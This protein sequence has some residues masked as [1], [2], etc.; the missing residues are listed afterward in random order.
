MDNPITKFQGWWKSALNQSPLKH[1]SA[2]CVSTIDR[3]GFPSGRFVDLKSVDEEGFMFCTDLDSQKGQQILTNSKVALT[4]WWD[5][6]GYQVRI[7]G[8]AE[9]VPEDEAEKHW[10]ARGRSAQLTTS[11]CKQSQVLESDDSLQKQLAEEE[12]R[13]QGVDVPKPANWGGF[14][15]RPESIEFLTFRET[16]LHKRE[17][18]CKED[19]ST[20]QSTLLQP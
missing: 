13:Y 5:H 16:R 1:K 11:C 17:L 14:R 7:Q 4:L 8:F 2:V 12:L 10:R 6:V 19:G 20:W 18:F 15:V 9:S 3:D